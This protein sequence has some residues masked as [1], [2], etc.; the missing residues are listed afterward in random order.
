MKVTQISTT[1]ERFARYNGVKGDMTQMHG[2]VY[3]SPENGRF[4]EGYR[5]SSVMA[6]DIITEGN[7]IKVKT[8]N[9]VYIYEKE[10]SN[11]N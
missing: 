10:T 11:V 2:V 8:R 7:T 4:G 1:N 9:S 3:F 5:T 6:S